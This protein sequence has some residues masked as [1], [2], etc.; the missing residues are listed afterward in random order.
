MKMTIVLNLTTDACK[1]DVV[2]EIKAVLEAIIAVG[3]EDKGIGFFRDATS[4]G[5]C[6]GLPLYDSNHVEVGK[7]SLTEN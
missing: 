7:I 2:A 1:K 4:Q 6:G 3:E 5:Y